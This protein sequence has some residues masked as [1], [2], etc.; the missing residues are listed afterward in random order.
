MTNEE[1]Y[2]IIYPSSGEQ[3]HGEEVQADDRLRNNRRRL[4]GSAHTAERVP[5]V[6][7]KR[8]NLFSVKLAITIDRTVP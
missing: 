1:S 3:P 4:T 5:A 2:V 7:I 6:F 8:Q